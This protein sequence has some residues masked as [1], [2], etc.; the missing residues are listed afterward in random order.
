[1]GVAA[2]TA[3]H[4][5][6]DRGWPAWLAFSLG[7]LAAVPAGALIGV[8]AV[9]LHGLFLAL[10]TLAFAFMAHELFFTE[11]VGLRERG[12]GAACLARQASRADTAFYYLVLAILL[13]SARSSPRTSGPDEPAGCS[14]RSATARR[15]RDRWGSTS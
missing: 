15:P 5:A 9:R 10:M 7:T 11:A 13:P 8:I 1:M 6:T 2:F 4:I 12:V 3:A 14:A